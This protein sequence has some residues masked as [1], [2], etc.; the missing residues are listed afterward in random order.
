M[1]QAQVL[2]DETSMFKLCEL[3][4]LTRLFFFFFFESVGPGLV[5]WTQFGQSKFRESTQ[6]LLSNHEK[7]VGNC[8]APEVPLWMELEGFP[9]IVGSRTPYKWF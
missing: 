2:Y 9:W 4:L 6:T 8:L 1:V 5:N 7:A 3:H